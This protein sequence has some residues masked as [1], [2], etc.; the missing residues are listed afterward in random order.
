M[1]EI[2]CGRLLGELPR[3]TSNDLK[4]TRNLLLSLYLSVC[5]LLPLC[6][7][8]SIYSGM[9][10]SNQQNGADPGRRQKERQAEGTT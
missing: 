1:S 10:H 4:C 2:L 9:R 8:Q 7:C 6:V 5:Q 3:T